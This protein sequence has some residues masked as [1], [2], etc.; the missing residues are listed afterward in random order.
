MGGGEGTK[1]KK[2]RDGIG[3]LSLLQPRGGE[4]GKRKVRSYKEEGGGVGSRN[5]KKNK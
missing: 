1:D 4:E 5:R 2:N 3:W